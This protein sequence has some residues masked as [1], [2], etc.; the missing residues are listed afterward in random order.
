[1]DERKEHLLQCITTLLKLGETPE[2]LA[3]SPI[4]DDFLNNS[5]KKSINIQYIPQKGFK[6]YKFTDTVPSDSMI[7]SL[8]K[9]SSEEITASNINRSISVTLI[10]GDPIA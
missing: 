3:N 2:K 1:M 6:I 9:L 4:L 7:V 10:S 8:S 5:D